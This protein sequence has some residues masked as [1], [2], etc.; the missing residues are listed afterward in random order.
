MPQDEAST[1]QLL[2]RLTEQLSTLVRDEAALAVVEVKTKARA[3]GVGVGVLVGAALFGFLGL[4]ALIACAIIALALVL[5][6]WLSALA[7][8]P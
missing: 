8:L 4:C 5:P 7:V 2:G 1:G 3:A 6:A